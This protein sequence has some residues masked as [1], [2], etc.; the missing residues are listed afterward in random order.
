M[1]TYPGSTPEQW[2]NTP[3]YWIQACLDYADPLEAADSL[4]AVTVGAMAAGRVA[5]RNA[6]P[7][8]LR[9]GALRAPAT[10]PRARGPAQDDAANRRRILAGRPARGDCLG[11][12]QE[13]GAAVFLHEARGLI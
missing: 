10:W 6:D 3:S 9:L 7:I 13:N 4:T 8:P 1:H 5:A 2:L 11:P 12:V